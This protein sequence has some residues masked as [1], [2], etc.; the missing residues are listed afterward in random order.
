M[1]RYV[2]I[3]ITLS[4]LSIGIGIVLEVFVK[5]ESPGTLLARMG[6]LI[7]IIGTT[8]SLRDFNN[9]YLNEFMSQEQAD[10]VNSLQD[11][12]EGILQSK[13]LMLEWREEYQRKIWLFE[14]GIIIFGT[15]LWGF[16]DLV[17]CTIVS[18]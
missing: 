16:G 14:A 11:R 15:F 8:I 4:L 6:A 10:K 7:V 17:Y 5:P 13:F 18:C 2:V 3:A 1:K 9:V 12:L